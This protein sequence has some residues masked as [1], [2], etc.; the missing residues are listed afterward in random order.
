MSYYYLV[1]IYRIVFYFIVIFIFF[2]Y[3][4]VGPRPKIKVHRAF[5][6]YGPSGPS[7]HQLGLTTV[8]I[9][10]PAFLHA[11]DYSHACMASL[12]PTPSTCRILFFHAYSPCLTTQ[13]GGPN[14][15]TPLSLRIT[16][17]EVPIGGSNL[18]RDQLTTLRMKAKTQVHLQQSSSR[19]K[20]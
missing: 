4:F 17:S 18:A 10:L 5:S 12:S 2:I 3:P 6:F 9:N 14:K 15:A 19:M 7:L 1:F 13:L 8:G 20:A 11:I 16:L